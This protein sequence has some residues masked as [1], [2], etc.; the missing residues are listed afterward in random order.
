MADLSELAGKQT[1][2]GKALALASIGIDTAMAIGSL[3]KNSEANPSNSV[4]FGGAGA[5]QF[6]IGLV[7]IIA[8]IKKAKDILSSPQTNPSL[9]GS[10]APSSMSTSPIQPQLPQAATTNLSQ[11]SINAL[12]NQAIKAYVVETDMTTNQQRIKAIQQRA[13]F[14]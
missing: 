8:N 9:G 10:S 4:T 5:L 12:G 14:G 3:T 11:S 1:K 2:I 6:A 7:R 13:R